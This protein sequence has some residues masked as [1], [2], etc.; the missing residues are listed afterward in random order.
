MEGTTNKFL[1]FIG[2]VCLVATGYMVLAIK[3]QVQYLKKDLGALHRN[4]ADGKDEINLL[5]AEWE[6]LN[7]PERLQALSDRY[8]G[9]N[10]AEPMQLYNG[11]ASLDS[12]FFLNTRQGGTAVAAADGKPAMYGFLTRKDA[13]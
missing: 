13:R 1:L 12:G 11:L 10:S 5:E 2:F 3:H 4:I 8:L 6:H 9:M 7:A